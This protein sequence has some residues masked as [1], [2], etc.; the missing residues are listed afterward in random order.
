MVCN[1]IQIDIVLDMR[2][3]VSVN[4]IFAWDSMPDAGYPA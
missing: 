2:K 4:G 3:H 1:T